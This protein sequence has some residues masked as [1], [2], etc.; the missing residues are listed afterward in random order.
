MAPDSNLEIEAIEAPALLKLRRSRRAVPPTEEPWLPC[1]HAM[2][3]GPRAR[4]YTG[5]I[6][7]VAHACHGCTV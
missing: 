1:M 2:A 3:R 7:I 4:M 6:A 5:P